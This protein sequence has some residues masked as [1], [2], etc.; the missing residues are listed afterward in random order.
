MKDPKVGCIL[1]K[2][3]CMKWQPLFSEAQHAGN[4]IGCNFCIGLLVGKL[5]A[6]YSILNQSNINSYAAQL[7][8]NLIWTTTIEII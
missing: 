4:F 3:G 5:F 1:S 6:I 8:H 2:A 7:I